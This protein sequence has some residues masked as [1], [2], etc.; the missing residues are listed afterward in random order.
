M[1]LYQALNLDTPIQKRKNEHI[2]EFGT[3][4]A[5]SVPT[6]RNLAAEIV[7]HIFSAL[8]DLG[9]TS[10]KSISSSSHKLA[11]KNPP[12]TEDSC[13]AEKTNKKY[14]HTDMIKGEIRREST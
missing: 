7:P 8:R 12:G 1:I 6:N 2:A 10:D 3:T 11:Y 14:T 13:S 4:K 9:V 5:T